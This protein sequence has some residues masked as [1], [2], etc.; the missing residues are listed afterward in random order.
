MAKKSFE[1]LQSEMETLLADNDTG[2][3]AEADVRAVFRD[4]MDTVTPGYA[5][6]A[7]TTM[8][9]PIVSFGTPITV[10]NWDEQRI[11]TPEFTVDLVAGTITTNVP[12]VVRINLDLVFRGDNNAQLDIM[13]H[14]QSTGLS[15]YLESET[16]RGN[17]RPVGGAIS[18]L[19][20]VSTPGE[21]LT[22]R[23][24]DQEGPRTYS[25]DAMSLIVEYI[26]L[27]STP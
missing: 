12:M 5:V 6:M 26:P 11:V 4:L 24:S 13:I 19:F 8:H 9:T 22:V 27:I 14:R 3:I 1:L 23:L 7:I 2:L 15:I 20:D 18:G 21:V 17:I 25:I 10:T 16:G